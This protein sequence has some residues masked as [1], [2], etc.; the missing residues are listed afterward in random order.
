MRAELDAVNVKDHIYKFVIFKEIKQM[1][2]GQ[3]FGELALRTKFTKKRAARIVCKKNSAFCT[4]SKQD[5]LRAVDMN[6]KK[7]LDLK[8]NFLK[9]FRIFAKLSFKKLGKIVYC[10]NV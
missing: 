7:E 8:I 4:L 1:Q 2:V 6:L 3:C 5:Y 9:L 10:M